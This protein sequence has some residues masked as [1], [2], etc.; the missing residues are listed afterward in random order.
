MTST[1]AYHLGLT[2]PADVIQVCSDSDC[3]RSL[4]IS[5]AIVFSD[6]TVFEL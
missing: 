6:G 5:H 3:I 2:G 4:I 1:V